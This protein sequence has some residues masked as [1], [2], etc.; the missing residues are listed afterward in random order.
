MRIHLIAIGGA[1]MHNLAL[2]LQANGHVVSGSD[3]EIY[4][5]ALTRLKAA[6]LCPSEFGWF[7]EKISEDLDVVILGMHA[8][9][10]NPELLKAQD[11][12]LKV[13]SYPEFIYEHS[14]DKK[15]IVIA[16]SHGKTTTT[17]IILH[18]LKNLGLEFDYLVG[19]AIEGFDRMVKLSEAAVIVVEGDEYL[20]S[21][22]DLRPKIHHYR[23]HVSVITGIAWDHIN[24]F[25]T[26]E[27]YKQQ[28][29]IFL[30]QHEPGAKVFYDGSDKDLCDV[31]NRV[32][33][34][35]LELIAYDA[36]KVNENRELVFEEETYEFPLIG[37]HN[38]KNTNAARLVCESL[39]IDSA[40]FFESLAG[41]TGAKKRLQLLWKN[42]DSQ[43]FLDFAHA[44]SKL[45]A[46]IDSVKE[47]FGDKKLVAFFELHTFSSLNAEFLNQYHHSMQMA[48]EAYVFFDEH[49][50]QMK[51]LP[52]VSE[53]DVKRHFGGSNVQ[54]IS[55]KTVLH[56][57]ITNY[58]YHL[59][60]VLF[61]TS[62]NFGGFDF[63]KFSKAQI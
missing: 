58:D 15:R 12:G 53:D 9:K 13:Y 48:D 22:I 19:S 51:G 50:L 32:Q 29:E 20:S 2:E 5:P 34:S 24:V 63:Q 61:M 49:T 46:T 11:L 7:P 10:N 59:C 8:K 27:I 62:G 43:A 38:L 17:S 56:E 21:P 35:D 60:L 44:P 23:P 41:F 54:V 4:D 55:N 3:D 37:Q 18:V 16:G 14:I 26:F 40:S 30:D 42:N 25:P 28:F 45:K 47:W 39:G 36:L 52:P 6:G 1:A 57:L 33:R 31:I